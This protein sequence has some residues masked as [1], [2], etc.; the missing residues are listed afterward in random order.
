[1]SSLHKPLW[2]VPKP[3]AVFL[4]LAGFGKRR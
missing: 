2:M 3:S 1:M 4:C